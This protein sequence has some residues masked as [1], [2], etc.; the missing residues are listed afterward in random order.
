MTDHVNAFAPLSPDERAESGSVPPPADAF[1]AVPWRGSDDAAV[2]GILGLFE[3]MGK[4]SSHYPY[5]WDFG[6]LAGVVLRWDY[7]PKDKTFRVAFH[8][9]EGGED[10]RWHARAPQ[11]DRPIFGLQALKGSSPAQLVV[12]HEGEKDAMRA[13]EELPAFVHITSL[14]GSNAANKTDWSQVKGRDVTIFR[15]GNKAGKEYAESVA[16]LCW[17]AEARSISIV[18]PPED[19]PGDWDFSW[20]LENGGYTPERLEKLINGATPWVAKDAKPRFS[21]INIAEFLSRDLPKR[22][23]LIDPVIPS[24]GLAMLYAERGVG[25]T[26]VGLTMAYAASTGLGALGWSV[27]EA[28][29]VLY[30]DGEMP[31]SAMQERIAMI[32]K[33]LG[34]RINP[35]NFRLITP[36]LQP[37]FCIPSLASPETQEELEPYLEGVDLIVIDNISTL[38]EHGRENEG[39]SW[40]P[41]QGWALRQRRLGRS[42]LFVHHAGKGGQQRGTSKR[43]DILDTVIVLRRPAN[44]QMEEGARFEVHLEKARG[45]TGDAASPFEAYLEVVDNAATWTLKKLENAHYDQ[46]AELSELGLSVR[47]IAEEIG[48]GKSTVHRYKRQ[49]EEKGD[50]GKQNSKKRGGK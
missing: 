10:P 21:V 50:M 28:R 34:S 47:E 23:M 9:Q 46:V 15:D 41:I 27:P 38:C 25:K 40:K 37:D 35:D 29:S 39:E 5:Y 3:K 42:V 24:Q 44:Y 30:I 49:A 7:G 16:R 17:D 13:H 8:G 31:A 33:G 36:D 1:E 11:S 26:L 20:A 43:E 18:Q 48:I 45:I 32:A 2:M 19:A 22:K 14:G 4:P 6:D 12:C